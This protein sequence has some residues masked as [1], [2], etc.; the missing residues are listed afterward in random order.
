M[1]PGSKPCIAHAPRYDHLERSLVPLYLANSRAIVAKG[2]LEV[3]QV[4][5]SRTGHHLRQVLEQHAG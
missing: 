2:R 1:N 3:A 4:E 5:E